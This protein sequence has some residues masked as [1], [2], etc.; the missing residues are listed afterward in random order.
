MIYVKSK[1]DFKKAD[2]FFER[3]LES[4]NLGTLD[5]YGRLGCQALADAT[6]KD[7]GKTALSWTYDIRRD[8]SGT[9]I[10]WS[11]TNDNKGVNIALL[12]QYGHGTKSG[13]YVSGRDYI[14]P[15][16][17]PIFDKI[18]KDAWEEVTRA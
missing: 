9:Y 10:V 5:K 18:A 3:L 1:G 4:V 6:P 11:N 2:R 8:Q 14:N 13:T 16:M 15:A 12:L 17:K 7:T